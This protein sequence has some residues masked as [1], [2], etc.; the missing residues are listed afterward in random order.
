MMQITQSTA[1]D[2]QNALQKDL[3]DLFKGHFYKS[4][5]LGPDGK[6]LYS[7][8]QVFRQNLPKRQS[9]NDPEPFPHIIVRLDSGRIAS[10]R[11]AHRV[12]VLLLVGTYNDDPMNSGHEA[13]IQIME[14]IHAHYAE[15]RVLERSFVFQDPFDWVLQDEESYP[16]FFGT[17][18]IIF[19][20]PAPRQKASVY[21]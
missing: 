8:P 14:K 13:V 2:L 17:A 11:D 10:Q 4:P 20:A 15:N 1:L 16:Y 18:R 7:E 3:T 9:E 21:T 12:A 19:D 5:S 6:S